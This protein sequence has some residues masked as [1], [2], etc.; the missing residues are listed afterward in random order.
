MLLYFHKT[1]FHG[2]VT[3][4]SQHSH[5]TATAQW[6]G[7]GRCGRHATVFPQKPA[8]GAT[9]RG[10]SELTLIGRYVAAGVSLR[11]TAAERCSGAVVLWCCAYSSCPLPLGY[12]QRSTHTRSHD[13]HSY[14]YPRSGLHPHRGRAFETKHT[15]S[16]RLC[17]T[18]P[19]SAPLLLAVVVT[20]DGTDHVP[21][22][23][24]HQKKHQ[25]KLSSFVFGVGGFFCGSSPQAQRTWYTMPADG[26]TP[27]PT[28]SAT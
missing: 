4:Q 20:A 23:Q 5:S 6:R 27:V 12:L 7:L 13:A 2:T 14:L 11:P 28:A 17:A 1:G 9:P 25:K 19:L 22:L 21:S 8:Y 18:R 16:D 10:P 15:F 26:S 3:A 24:P